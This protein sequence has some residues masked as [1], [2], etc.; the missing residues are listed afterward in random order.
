MKIS[1]SYLFFKEMHE[2]N[3]AS[4]GELIKE[5]GTFCESGLMR[6]QNFN[7][8][9]GKCNMVTTAQII[10]LS[11]GTIS[12]SVQ[13]LTFFVRF[14]GFCGWVL[15]LKTLRLIIQITTTE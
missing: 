15:C 4:S 2:E 14:K 3:M 9:N 12:F 13:V 1:V 6:C 8:L 5:P 7:N 11:I 10:H